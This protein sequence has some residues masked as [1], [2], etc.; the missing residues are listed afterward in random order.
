RTARGQVRTEPAERRRT[1]LLQR[2]AAVGLGRRD[3]DEEFAPTPPKAVAPMP[4]MAQVPPMPQVPAERPL[5]RPAAPRQ[6]MRQEMR[7]E[8][9]PQP[10]SP[11]A[12]RPA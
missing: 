8:P 6:D 4:A 7:A 12:Q 9:P 10:G 2:L 11:Y 3:D 1:S 5:S